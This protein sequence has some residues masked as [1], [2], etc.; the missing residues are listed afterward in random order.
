MREISFEEYKNKNGNPMTGV[1][2]PEAKYF[3]SNSG[4]DL[5]VVVKTDEDRYRAHVVSPS[6]YFDTK[7]SENS[8]SFNK[9]KE[10]E[11]AENWLENQ[12]G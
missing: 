10:W 12:I 1:S 4:E 6:P 11:D 5:G 7:R 3:A 2:A 8:K 9:R